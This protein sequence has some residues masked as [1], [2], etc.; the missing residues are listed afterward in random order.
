MLAGASA[1]LMRLGFVASVL[2]E[3]L[4]ASGTCRLRNASADRLRALIDRNL[5]TLD[6]I[7]SFLDR[8]DV[9]LYRI[10]SN[11]IPFA[12]HPVN[13]LAWWHEFAA[14][15]RH[16]GRRL[17]AFGIRVSTHPGQFTVLNSPDHRV[18][19]TAVAELVYHAR[20]LDAMDTD[21]SCKIVLHIGGLYGTTTAAAL[22][23]FSRN[24][25]RLPARVLRRL[26]IENDDRLFDA[27]EV[28][29]VSRDTGLPVV[30]DWL[31][32][33]THPCVRPV[34]QILP[35][36]FD[37]WR[38]ADGR[39]K[40]HL[41]S[42]AENARPGAHADFVRPA[43]LLDLMR[44]A[45]RHPFDCMLEAKEKDRAVFRLRAELNTLGISERDD[46]RT[47]RGEASHLQSQAASTPTSRS[48][49]DNRIRTKR[50]RTR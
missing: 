13:T 50:I 46:V 4:S 45:P 19:R 20:L 39:P 35:A 15:L 21:P 9:R 8:H 27:E 3:G 48:T 25:S 37:T 28:L 26:V 29:S 49:D 6:K 23:R 44:L 22:E 31:H 1:M 10:T 18:V 42:Q 11:L 33:K 41:S 16:L 5:S 30:F 32:H 17:R 36:I 14:D 2:T 43:D 24:A 38:H 7:L 34:E 12:S 40:V 47:R